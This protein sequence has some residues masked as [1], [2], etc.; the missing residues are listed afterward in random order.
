M[1]KNKKGQVTIFIIL[2]VLIVGGI[3]GLLFLTNGPSSEAPSKQGPSNFVRSCARDIVKESVQKI[4]DS[5]GDM[6]PQKSVMYQGQNY[7]FLC[8][9]AD[10]YLP[11]YS[12]YPGLEKKIE[13]EI[14]EDTVDAVKQCFEEFKQDSEDKGFLVNFRK[15]EYSIDLLPGGVK[16]NLQREVTVSKEGSSQEFENFDAKIL[17]SLY[18]LV[19]LAREVVNDESKFCAFE[20]V[21]YMLLYADYDIRRINYNSNRIYKL[22]NR[23]TSEEFKFAV[24]GC[25]YPPGI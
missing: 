3:V 16:I 5:G 10:N 25:T 21:G 20:Y 18:E 12:L 24:R 14:R 13:L 4:L 9:Q 15:M 22:I 8:Y 7:T 17:S 1:V 23:K 2:G 11:C 19:N 6:T